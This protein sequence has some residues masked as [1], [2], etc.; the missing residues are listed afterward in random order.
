MV[1][2]FRTMTKSVRCTKIMLQFHDNVWN[3]NF[4]AYTIEQW[5]PGKCCVLNLHRV[6]IH[7]FWFVSFYSFGSWFLC[8]YRWLFGHCFQNTYLERKQKLYLAYWHSSVIYLMCL[9][10]W[11]G[12]KCIFFLLWSGLNLSNEFLGTWGV[13]GC[14]QSFELLQLRLH[15]YESFEGFGFGCWFSKDIM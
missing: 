8:S 9:L 15:R 6:V 2:V 11:V 14:G 4:A 5:V 10:I 12:N 3:V 1:P 7:I 13:A